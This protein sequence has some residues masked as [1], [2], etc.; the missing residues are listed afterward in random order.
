MTILRESLYSYKWFMSMCCVLV[1]AICMVIHMNRWLLVRKNGKA[2]CV[3]CFVIEAS[4]FT[5]LQRLNYQ[6]PINSCD[7]AERQQAS[8]QLWHTDRSKCA[9][10][11]TSLVV[12][13][14]MVTSESISVQENQMPDAAISSSLHALA[15]I[16]TRS[17]ELLLGSDIRLVRR[18]RSTIAYTSI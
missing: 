7:P 1:P 17:I 8:T 4:A 10:N 14:A 18:A 2:R 6:L 16:L 3:Q 13:I 5:Y 12:V 9:T 11:E 15:R